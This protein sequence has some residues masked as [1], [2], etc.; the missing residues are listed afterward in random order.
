M[1]GCAF[2]CGALVF[3]TIATEQIGKSRLSIC[4]SL[5]PSREK[6][7]ENGHENM[8]FEKHRGLHSS[9]HV[10]NEDATLRFSQVSYARIDLKLQ[11]RRKKLILTIKPAFVIRMIM[12]SDCWKPQYVGLQP[13]PVHNSQV[14]IHPLRKNNFLSL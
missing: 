1:S 3:S 7:T 13:I 11:L 8:Q 2:D 5:A 10:K 9:Q 4:C 6:C 14:S 12:V